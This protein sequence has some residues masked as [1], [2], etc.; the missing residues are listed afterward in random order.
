[1]PT[2]GPRLFTEGVDD[3]PINLQT[4]GGDLVSI[5][6]TL[7]EMVKDVGG[8]EGATLADAPGGLEDSEEKEEYL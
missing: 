3:A 5:Y 4:Y 6:A 2:C 7:S 1:M 8:F